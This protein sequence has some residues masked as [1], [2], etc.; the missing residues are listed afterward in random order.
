[1]RAVSTALVP[2]PAPSPQILIDLG[3]RAPLALL[4][5]ACLP[6]PSPR[7]RLHCDHALMRDPLLTARVLILSISHPSLRTLPATRRIDLNLDLTLS[8]RAHHPS[9]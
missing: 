8:P 1:M 3:P 2:A 7:T 5:L 9:Q 4:V 6:S